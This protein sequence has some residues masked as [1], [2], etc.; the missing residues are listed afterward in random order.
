MGP[1]LEGLL[2]A[3]QR[4]PCLK[5]IPPIVDGRRSTCCCLPHCREATFD[6]ADGQP[7]SVLVQPC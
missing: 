6:R 3:V 7:E 5:A 1:S 2:M 4:T